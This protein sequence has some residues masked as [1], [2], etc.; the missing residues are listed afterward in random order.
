[1][2]KLSYFGLMLAVNTLSCGIFCDR[3]TFIFE[4]NFEPIRRS[5]MTASDDC[6]DGVTRLPLAYADE[7]SMTVDREADTVTFTYMM[8][9]TRVVETWR[10][11]SS[12]LVLD[13]PARCDD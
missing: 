1:M 8:G 10:I 13:V 7:V 4:G 3:K 12:D 9:I 6:C 2:R 11:T 5:Q